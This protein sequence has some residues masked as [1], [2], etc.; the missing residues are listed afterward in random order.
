MHRE[1]AEILS[2]LGQSDKEISKLET[3][4]SLGLKPDQ[5]RTH[6]DLA[7]V[8]EAL[9]R[10]QEAQG[11]F[12]EAIRLKPDFAEAHY[13]L[14]LL[15]VSLGR[16]DDAIKEFKASL[17]YGPTNAEAHDALG[18]LFSSP[19]NSQMQSQSSWKLN[20]SSRICPAS[21]RI[22]K[23]HGVLQEFDSCARG[24]GGFRISQS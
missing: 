21:G 12:P 3:A 14:G 7:I 24:G 9:N 11:H 18:P 1:L 4:Q 19:V 15:L 22:W 16:R 2:R 8:L 5:P 13:N 10:P 23:S 17:R 6:N 20:A